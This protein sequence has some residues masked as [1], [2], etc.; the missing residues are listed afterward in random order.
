MVDGRLQQ[1]ECGRTRRVELTVT[2]SN[3]LSKVAF[4]TRFEILQHVTGLSWKDVDIGLI[5][6]LQS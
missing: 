3:K 6:T 2:F 1:A 5:S 4:A